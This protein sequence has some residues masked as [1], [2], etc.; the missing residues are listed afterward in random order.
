[1]MRVM[2]CTSTLVS[3]VSHDGGYDA[4]FDPRVWDHSWWQYYTGQLVALNLISF[5][6]R[7]LKQLRSCVRFIDLI[8]VNW[9]QHSAHSDKL[10]GEPLKCLPLSYGNKPSE[11]MRLKVRHNVLS[12]WKNIHHRSY[13][14]TRVMIASLLL[15]NKNAEVLPCPDA[16]LAAFGSESKS[17]TTSAMRWQPVRQ[18]S[19]HKLS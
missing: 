2:M 12:L 7:D 19:K 6:Q 15:F 1:M 3:R 10:K 18:L 5:H 9:F 16:I 4:Y 8:D 13:V 11:I 17:N 14:V